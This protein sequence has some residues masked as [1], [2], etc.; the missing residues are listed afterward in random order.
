MFHAQC[1][2]LSLSTDAFHDLKI[3][4]YY[5]YLSRKLVFF[6]TIKLLN[7]LAFDRSQQVNGKNTCDAVR[8]LHANKEGKRRNLLQISLNS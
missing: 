3:V 6:I 2:E 8:M 7:P 5:Y 4:I 1:R